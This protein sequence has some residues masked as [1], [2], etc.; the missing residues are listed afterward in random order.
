MKS[1]RVR[2]KSTAVLIG[3][4]ALFVLLLAAPAGGA[5]QAATLRTIP[6][7]EATF[8]SEELTATIQLDNIAGLFGYQV[9][10]LY[11]PALVEA[12]GKFDNSFFNTS[13]AFVLSEG[14]SAGKCLFAVAFFGAVPSVA[15]SGPLASV[16]L[17]ARDSGRFDLQFSANTLLS[18]R[19][20]LP[21]PV[22]WPNPAL[23]LTVCGAASISGTV[24]LQGR[25][26]GPGTPG[27]IRLVNLEGDYE[28]VIVPFDSVSGAFSA[29]EVRAESGGSTYRVEAGHS[30]Y[31]TNA[32]ES[33]A[34]SVGEALVLPGTGLRAGDANNDGAIDILDMACIGAAYERGSSCDGRGGSDI[35]GDGQTSLP[36]L[37]LAGGN[38]G[39]SGLQVW[40]PLFNP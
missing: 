20:G 14:C 17:A 29:A 38:Y 8:C 36:D 10:L 34:I 26:G 21:I 32:I 37:T 13:G 25:P 31:L 12:A 28:D 39:L 7:G 27:E 22:S 40:Q 1:F 5:P 3:V 9:E 4:A 30:L 15:G 2:E 35:N 33:V 16:T 18:D 23:A 6:G 19:D 11:D 24:D